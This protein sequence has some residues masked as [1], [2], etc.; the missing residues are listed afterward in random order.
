[1]LHL[2][3]ESDD[4]QA[5][6]FLRPIQPGGFQ[7]SVADNCN[8]SSKVGRALNCPL[9]PQNVQLQITNVRSIS[10]SSY[11]PL[12]HWVA[13]GSRR[14]QGGEKPFPSGLN[15]ANPRDK[16]PSQGFM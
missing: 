5:A 11:E 8:L 9:C 6:L 1:M 15:S 2:G 14:Y 3:I 13:S 16:D 7:H 10:S 4:C 12:F